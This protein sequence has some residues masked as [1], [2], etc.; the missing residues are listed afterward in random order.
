L[1]VLLAPAGGLHQELYEGLA[2][3]VGALVGGVAGKKW[4]T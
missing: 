3:A 2:P 1:S 4:Q